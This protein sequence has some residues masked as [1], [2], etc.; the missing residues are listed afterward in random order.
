MFRKLLGWSKW[1]LYKSDEPYIKATFES[2]LLGN[3]IINEDRVLIDIYVKTNERTG[4][5][6][7]KRVIKYR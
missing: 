7:Y 1:D 2:P 4:L 6:K 5:K 3:K